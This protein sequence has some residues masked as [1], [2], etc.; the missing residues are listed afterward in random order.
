MQ[1]VYALL[2]TS[3]EDLE[4]KNRLLQNT[5]WT[6]AGDQYLSSTGIFNSSR[7]NTGTCMPVR[8]P[9][10]MTLQRELGIEPYI[11]DAAQYDD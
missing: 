6:Y 1:H 5:L 7:H 4:Q 3:H 2:F 11:M 8:G 10:R 9:Y